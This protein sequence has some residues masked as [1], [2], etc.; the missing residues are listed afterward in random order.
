MIGISYLFICFS[1]GGSM[2]GR[3]TGVGVMYLYE[4]VTGHPH[5]ADEYWGWIDPG[6]FAILGAGCLL[7]GVTRLS[8]AITVIIVSNCSNY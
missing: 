3:A 8:L 5:V 7:G 4:Y 1:I 6:L 2:Y